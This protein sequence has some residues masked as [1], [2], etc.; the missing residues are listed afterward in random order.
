MGQCLLT[1]DRAT[2]ESIDINPSAPAVVWFLTDPCYQRRLPG[3]PPQGGDWEPLFLESGGVGMIHLKDRVFVKRDGATDKARTYVCYIANLCGACHAVPNG[4]CI[5]RV[6]TSGPHLGH[7]GSQLSASLPPV[8]LSWSLLYSPF[9]GESHRSSWTSGLPSCLACSIIPT[10]LVCIC[11]VV[12]NRVPLRAICI[13]PL[14]GTTLSKTDNR[15]RLSE[16][17]FWYS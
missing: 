14:E 17:S 9:I 2:Y 1:W 10:I 12:F 13:R 4:N 6:S 8:L 15:T 5:L 3:G 7:W 11:S 16:Q